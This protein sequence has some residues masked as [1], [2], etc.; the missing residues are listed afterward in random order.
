MKTYGVHHVGLTVEN[1]E[2]TAEFFT[3]LLGFERVKER[4][5]YPAIFVSDGVNMITLWEVQD[6]VNK[7]AFDRRNHIG[8]HHIAFKVGSAD[9]LKAFHSRLEQAGVVIEFAP[10]NIGDGPAQHMMCY[11]PSGVRIELYTMGV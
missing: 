6:V 1:V 5:D 10:E 4:P 9:V 8:L 11:E 3:Q 7:V 2:K